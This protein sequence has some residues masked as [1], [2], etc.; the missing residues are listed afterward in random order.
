M[1]TPYKVILRRPWMIDFG[2]FLFFHAAKYKRNGSVAVVLM[3]TYAGD[4]TMYCTFYTHSIHL[5]N[6]LYGI[7]VYIDL[8]NIKQM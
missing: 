5:L 6:L 2:I 7:F 1:Q 8:L 4:S 3:S